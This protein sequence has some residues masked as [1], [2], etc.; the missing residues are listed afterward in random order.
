VAQRIAK[1]GAVTVDAAR[2]ALN[3]IE[4]D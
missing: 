1:R 2:E 4:N 3:E